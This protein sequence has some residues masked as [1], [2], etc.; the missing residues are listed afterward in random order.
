MIASLPRLSRRQSRY[1]TFIGAQERGLHIRSL[2]FKSSIHLFSCAAALNGYH[3][4]PLSKQMP[5]NL[6]PVSRVQHQRFQMYVTSNMKMQERLWKKAVARRLAMEA[7]VFDRR[8]R[9]R[10]VDSE[11]GAEVRGL[12]RAISTTKVISLRI[13]FLTLAFIHTGLQVYQGQP[14]PGLVRHPNTKM[15]HITCSCLTVGHV[16]GIWRPYM[17][18][19]PSHSLSQLDPKPVKVTYTALSL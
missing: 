11:T 2:C 18:K 16:R 3:R 7:A 15:C 10:P 19:E 17:P 5:L 12:C 8:A 14:F 9:L 6:S 13:V 1:D 4:G